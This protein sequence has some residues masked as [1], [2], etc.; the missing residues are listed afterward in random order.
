MDLKIGMQLT[1][2]P[3]V[4]ERNERFRCKVVEM[5]EHAFY[6]DYPVNVLTRKTAFLMDGAEFKVTFVDGESSYVFNSEVLGRKNVGIP[7]ISL[8]QPQP[9]EVMKIQR[10]E[11]VR[12]QTAV[13]VALKAGERSYQLTTEDISAGGVAVF[14]RGHEQI[15]ENMI[16]DLTIVLPFSNGDIHYVMSEAKVVR[17]FERDQVKIA[18][19]QF[20]DPIDLD[21]QFIVRFCFERQILLR[22]KELNI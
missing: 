13:D 12:V 4:N 19:I 21:Q 14:L 6:I 11:F 3:I 16:V 10:R 2:E 17:I 9:E 1:L 18:S 15:E 20:V 7:T 8:K 22:K 5:E